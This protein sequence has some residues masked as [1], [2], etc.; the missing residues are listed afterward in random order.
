MEPQYSCGTAEALFNDIK[1]N[2]NPEWQKHLDASA[3]L[4][5]ALDGISGVPA[6]DGGFHSSFDH[7]Y[8]NLS[9]RQCHAK[10]LPCKL[11]DGHNSTSCVSQKHADAVYRMGNWEY[12]QIYRDHPS[13]LPASALSLGIWI[14]ELVIHLRDVIS[15]SSTTRYFHNI[16]HDGSVS[17]L[18]SILQ[19]DEMVW[20]GMGSEVVFELYKR[21]EH[22]PNPHPSSPLAAPSC[23]HDNCLRHMIRHFTSVN[24]LCHNLPDPSSISPTPALPFPSECSDHP[25]LSSACACWSNLPTASP[26][27]SNGPS[28]KPSGYYIRVLFGG[29]VFQSSNPNL[30]RL[31]MV[32]AEVLLDYLE[33]LV[34]KSGGPIK[35]KCQS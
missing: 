32:P 17:R 23:R 6:S 30:G 11:L 2:R 10:P 16:A 14:G 7:Y 35:S 20:P 9:A 4:F 1:S 5:S 8:D 19:I 31:D 25:Q 13:S 29:K 28:S 33:A 24:T 15:G 12:S 18:L 3:N 34:G 26:L 21:K 22:V 27:P